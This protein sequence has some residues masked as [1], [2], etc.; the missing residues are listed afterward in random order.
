M[1]QV[2][3]TKNSGQLVIY[4]QKNHLSSQVIMKITT[5]V[6]SHTNSLATQFDAE[7]LE[8]LL[9]FLT[10]ARYGLGHHLERSQ[11]DNGDLNY[12]CNGYYC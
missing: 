3:R 9:N 8:M 4:T 7:E 1:K 10:L 5:K 2:I 12:K 6:G 11:T